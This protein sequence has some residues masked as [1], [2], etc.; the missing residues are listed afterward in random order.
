M[1]NEPKKKRETQKSLR[2]ALKEI[3]AKLESVSIGSKEEKALLRE[4]VRCSQKLLRLMVNAEKRA[5]K[6][7]EKSQ[8]P[9]GIFAAA[10]LG[11]A[12]ETADST[13]ESAVSP[14]TEPQVE[15]PDEDITEWLKQLDKADA[16]PPI[17]EGEAGNI[18]DELREIVGGG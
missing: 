8:Q 6:K 13:T 17:D 11:L 2:A 14:P 9:E 3:R 1:E 12:E 7:L 5:Q 16:I 10:V 15:K 4:D 18:Q